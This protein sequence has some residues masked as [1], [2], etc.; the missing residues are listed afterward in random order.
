MSTAFIIYIHP[1]LEV[2]QQEDTSA[3]L[4]VLLSKTTDTT[5][6]DGT[7]EVPQWIDP[8]PTI[9]A[10]EILLYLSL[11]S[12]LAVVL[13]AILAKQI[14][15]L[16]ASAGKSASEIKSQSANSLPF[17]ILAFGLHA[18]IVLLPALLQG[19]ILL[20]GFGVTIYVWKIN[21]PIASPAVIVIGFSLLVFI[22]FAGAVLLN[23]WAS[24]LRGR[25]R[26]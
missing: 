23:L 13:F 14:L 4:R 1:R 2:D 26:S 16:Y 24:H 18:G 17:R 8:P 19:S 25:V 6:T 12:E 9:I 7:P 15:H 5:F 21:T 20:F 22:P 3:L 11:A 10:A